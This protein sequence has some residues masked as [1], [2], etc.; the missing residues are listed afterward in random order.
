MER[1]LQG[2]VKEVVVAHKD[3]WVKF[4]FEF[5][6]WLFIQFGAIIHSD[7]SE[8]D[9]RSIITEDLMAIM[10][11]YTAKYNGTRKYNNKKNTDIPKLKDEGKINQ[12]I[13]DR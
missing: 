1:L 8:R 3:R 7:S 13:L 2:Q 4:G 12:D 10:G 11:I 9:K 6:E 5:F